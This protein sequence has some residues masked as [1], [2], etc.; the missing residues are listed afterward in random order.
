[1]S[2]ELIP[3]D[4]IKAENP[5]ENEIGENDLAQMAAQIGDGRLIKMEVDYSSQVDE[6]LP[7]ASAIARSGD[8]AGAIELLTPLEKQSRLGSDMKSNTRVLQHMVRLAFE[9]EKWDLLNDLITTMSKKRSIIKFSIKN[10][11]KYCCENLDN[12]TDVEVKNKLID[13]LRTVTAGK[14]YVEVERARLT[15]RVVQ[16]LESEN[17][18]DE[19]WDL[20][21]DLQVETYGSMEIQE[22]VQFL[23]HQ[24]R[25]SVARKD[26][27]RASIIS[28]KISTKF[29]DSDAA[30]IQELKL[31]FYGYMI[32]VGLHDADYLEVC[33]HFR[34]VFETPMI[35]DD[36]EKAFEVL[37][38]IVLYILLAQHGN[39]QWDLIHRINATRELEMI[40]QYKNLLELF[41]NEEVILWK[42]TIVAKYQFLR[43]IVPSSHAAR[44]FEKNEQGEQRWSRFK[45]RVGEHN[46]RMVS[47]YYIQITF[48]RMA[49]ILEF[50]VD[51]MESFLCNLIVTGVIPDAKIHRP[52]RIINLRARHANIETLDQW[53]SNVRKLTDIL[54]KVSH[55]I[56]KEEMVHRHLEK[57]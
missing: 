45:E 13:T 17:K 47:K 10:M 21:I 18:L 49:E 37:K 42:E 4:P 3:V 28:K 15:K 52:S 1:M 20:I 54:N 24:M 36:Q 19:A 8:V 44:V 46:V 27:V 5:T 23:L 2:R 11:I 22:K 55:L 56:L 53:G 29:F 26:Y 51:E 35:K 34:A 50:P 57:H 32:E 40:P 43:E 33:R 6:A 14:I 38:C 31:E 9:S 12:I 41:I 39:E 30:E 48:E 25:L 7:K 16:K